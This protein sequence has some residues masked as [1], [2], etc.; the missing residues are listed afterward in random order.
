MKKYLI[1]ILFLSFILP[2]NAQKVV[3]Y[4]TFYPIPYGSHENLT[5]SKIG[6]GEDEGKAYINGSDNSES[7]IDGSLIYTGGTQYKGNLF[8][9][10]F[11]NNT[12]LG[13][14]QGLMKSGNG[15]NT[16]SSYGTVS[17]YDGNSSEGTTITDITSIADISV[18]DITS[19]PASSTL[20]EHSLSGILECREGITWQPLRLAGTEE[21]K[22]YLICSTGSSGTG[23]G[24]CDLTG[25]EC[26]AI[27]CWN[28]SSCVNNPGNA[29]Q[30]NGR[31]HYYCQDSAWA[32][33][34]GTGW[35]CN[36]K[37]F[38]PKQT[39]GLSV[40]NEY[41][42]NASPM[43]TCSSSTVAYFV[44]GGRD[45]TSACKIEGGSEIIT[46]SCNAYTTCNANTS[47]PG[48]SCEVVY[49]TCVVDNGMG[50]EDGEHGCTSEQCWD[51]SFC[52]NN[53]GTSVNCT[54]WDSNSSGGILTRNVICTYG[55]WQTG[56]YYG[57]C[58]CNNGY[59]WQASTNP[60]TSGF[61]KAYTLNHN[62]YTSSYFYSPESCSSTLSYA[63]M[64]AQNSGLLGVIT[65][66]DCCEAGCKNQSETYSESCSCNGNLCTF[67]VD[68]YRCQK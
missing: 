55:G 56:S 61:C 53:P 45:A 65:V 57:S 43:S 16:I 31:C 18:A 14:A 50:C 68:E 52:R 42:S 36:N 64:S 44:A 11:N 25:N 23:A 34:S 4:I 22:H 51:G 38:D 40:I 49:L 2:L 29:H 37:I 58:T 41:S 28:G 3:R 48:Y 20:N 27:Q 63:K 35:N 5:V 32:C 54:S 13:T 8:L 17:I 12:A 10:N 47:G 24:G 6:S 26:S 9:N 66:S 30:F 60:N 46:S 39:G 62:H 59:Y 1:L 67:D 21:C 15:S 19:L 33:Q 7:I